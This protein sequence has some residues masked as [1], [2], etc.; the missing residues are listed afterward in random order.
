MPHELSTRSFRLQV[1]ANAT[2]LG[3]AT[4]FVI[5]HQNDLYLITNRHVL[6]GRRLANNEYLENLRTPTHLELTYVDTGDSLSVAQTIVLPLIDESTTP[7]TFLWVEH[8]ERAEVDV[9]A[10]RLDGI[11]VGL[12]LTV[13][14]NPPLPDHPEVRLKNKV[15]KDVMVIGYPEDLFGGSP[16]IG[17]W[18][19]GIVASEPELR[20]H[21]RSHYLIDSRTAQGMSGSPVY[22]YQRGGTLSHHTHPG[23][24]SIIGDDGIFEL[25]GVYSG[26]VSKRTDLG[27]VWPQAVIIELLD[28]AVTGDPF[29]M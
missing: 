12:P 18:V 21:N 20:L 24:R 15:P 23:L 8:P 25:A 26:R 7:P 28:N 2:R 29:Y 6:S 11:T 14:D 4:G 19:Q 27:F 13:L 16:G 22:L 3:Q 9:A 10:L 5:S 1:F 17:V